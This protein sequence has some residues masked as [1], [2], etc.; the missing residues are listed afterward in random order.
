[1]KIRG[2]FQDKITFGR[3]VNVQIRKGRKENEEI[4]KSSAKLTLGIDVV[5]ILIHI[6]NR[7]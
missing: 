2:K 6:T 5:S 3:E 4:V 7:R 1:M